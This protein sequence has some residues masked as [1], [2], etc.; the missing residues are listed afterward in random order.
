MPAHLRQNHHSDP[1]DCAVAA[2]QRFKPN[3]VGGRKICILGLG[4]RHEEPNLAHRIEVGF[5][6]WDKCI[7]MLQAE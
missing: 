3:L 7:A 5:S 1:K 6:C 2:L 4:M